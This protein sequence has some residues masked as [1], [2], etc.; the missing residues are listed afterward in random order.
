MVA[1]DSICCLSQSKTW[2]Y[3]LA[4]KLHLISPWDLDTRINVVTSA[5]LPFVVNKNMYSDA[6]ANFTPLPCSQVHF[7][8]T[9]K[10]KAIFYVHNLRSHV[11]WRRFERRIRVWNYDCKRSTF[12]SL[13]NSTVK[14][15][16]KMFH[17]ITAIIITQTK[18]AA[19]QTGRQLLSG[20]QTCPK[21]SIQQTSE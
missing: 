20:N 16:L 15:L 8:K 11:V 18:T 3:K 19:K 1:V 21:R 6:S 4:G 12:T 17:I 13:P 9:D 10:F 7:S 5:L 2:R 14:I